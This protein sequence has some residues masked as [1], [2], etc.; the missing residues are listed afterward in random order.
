M[1]IEKQTSVSNKAM[2]ETDDA[3]TLR[4]KF[5]KR[6]SRSL[7]FVTQKFQLLFAFVLGDFFAPFLFQVAHFKASSIF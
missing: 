4:K 6:N 7:V 3:N 2:P 1:V 5:R